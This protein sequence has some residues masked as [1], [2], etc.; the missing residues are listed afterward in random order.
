MV[1][2]REL[3]E[4][5]LFEGGIR[6]L[7]HRTGYRFSI[8]AVLLGNF[9]E[10]KPSDRILDLG[11]GCGVI[12]LILAYRNPTASITGLEI[13]PELAAL[14]R[15]NAALNN[16]QDR[17]EVISGDLREIGNYIKPESFDWIG[18]SLLAVCFCSFIIASTR[19]A[20]QM[21]AIFQFFLFKSEN[22]KI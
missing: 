13:Q 16:W 6:C 14:A 18:A 20:G 17:I 22:S 11:S 8:D 19:I 7:Q 5:T 4:D 3:T 21:H 12:P 1:P 2:D 10:P 15:K 9:V